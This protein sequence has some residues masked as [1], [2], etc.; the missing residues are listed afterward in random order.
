[1]LSAPDGSLCM[2]RNKTYSTK[3]MLTQRRKKVNRYIKI[4]AYCFLNLLTKN[5]AFDKML[6]DKIQKEKINETD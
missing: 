5:F 3:G 2:T 1:M 6:V 4:I